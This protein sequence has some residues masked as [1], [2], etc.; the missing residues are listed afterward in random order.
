MT[1]AAAATGAKA[2]SAQV[3]FDVPGGNTVSHLGYWRGATFLGSRALRNA[4]NTADQ[5]ETFTGQGTYTVASG[6][7]TESLT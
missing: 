3:V 5:T 2:S 7:I 1:W 6:A 4:G